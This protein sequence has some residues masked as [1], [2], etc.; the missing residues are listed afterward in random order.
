VKSRRSKADSLSLEKMLAGVSIVDLVE[1]AQLKLV[2]QLKCSEAI[3]SP[4]FAI[5][6]IDARALKP[7]GSLP[8]S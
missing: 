7:P 1:S 2:C 8:D 6:S 4:T 5:R 3:C